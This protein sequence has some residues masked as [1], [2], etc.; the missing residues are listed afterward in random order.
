MSYQEILFFNGPFGHW[1]WLLAVGRGVDRAVPRPATG[2]STGCAIRSPRRYD[3]GDRAPR[4]CRRSTARYSGRQFATLKSALLQRSILRDLQAQRNLPGAVTN[5]SFSVPK[6]STFGVI[7]RNGSGKSTRAQA[8]RRHHQADQRQRSR[9]T[10]RIS[11]LD[12]ARRGISPGDLRPRER[13]HQR[14]HAR[15]DE[16]AR[17]R[18]DSTTSSISPSCA[19]SSTPR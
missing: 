18:S 16:A 6:G 14:H 13:L 19:S 2:C 15:P 7:G 1:K 17:S 8:R 12:R 5:V 10:D 9:S 3:A 4:T 11:A